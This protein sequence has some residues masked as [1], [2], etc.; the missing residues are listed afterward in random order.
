MHT[1]RPPAMDVGVTLLTVVIHH[2]RAG[3]NEVAARGARE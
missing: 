3:R 2:Q 1:V